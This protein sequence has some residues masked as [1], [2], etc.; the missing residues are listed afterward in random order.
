MLIEGYVLIM[1]KLKNLLELFEMEPKFEVKEDMELLDLLEKQ[2]QEEKK[3]KEENRPN[4]WKNEEICSYCRAVNSLRIDH[5]HGEVVCSKCRV[6][7]E[8]RLFD[9]TTTWDKT[10]TDGQLGGVRDDYAMDVGL[11]TKVIPKG[12]GHNSL[13]M[14]QVKTTSEAGDKSLMRG[15]RLVTS[16]GELLNLPAIVLTSSKDVL[17]KIIRKKK[18][19]GRNLEALTVAILYTCAKVNS[20]PRNLNDVAE[21]TGMHKKEILRCIKTVNKFCKV[22]STALDSTMVEHICN[23]MC[24]NNY[25]MMDAIEVMKNINKLGL[26]SGRNPYTVAGAAIFTAATNLQPSLEIRDIAEAIQM[27][28]AT[29]R[30]TIK[31]LQP[32]LHKLLTKEPINVA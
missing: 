26:L 29:L 11:N 10:N 23:R 21:R 27:S 20:N 31:D 22:G 15:C 28:E 1:T 5:V 12:A 9:E 3:N 4:K 13:A 19:K 2:S 25:I 7:V 30:Y 6:V 16:F 17:K 14:I 32:H 18:L 8:D 24:L